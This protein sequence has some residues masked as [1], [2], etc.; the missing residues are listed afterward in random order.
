[1]FSVT[2][3]W[4]QN[5]DHVHRQ[6]QLRET[7]PT[8]ETVQ[9]AITKAYQRRF[10]ELQ[11]SSGG[12]KIVNR[13]EVAVHKGIEYLIPLLEFS[14]LQSI[15]LELRRKRE[16]A[17]ESGLGAASVVSVRWPCDLPAIYNC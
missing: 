12:G 3:G 10:V 8:L 9:T 14:K 6:F 4:Y 13:V 15:Y 11:G 7:L 1:M 17:K 2:V 5:A 16:E